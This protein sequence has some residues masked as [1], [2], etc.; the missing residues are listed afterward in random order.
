MGLDEEKYRLKYTV[1]K[2]LAVKITRRADLAD[3]AQEAVDRMV[4]ILELESGWVSFF[5][6]KQNVTHEALSG[7]VDKNQ[8]I[9]EIDKKAIKNL[10]E[11]FGAGF[12]FF[13][14]EKEGSQ[15][16]FS[17]SIKCEKKVLGAIT[18][19]SKGETDFSSEKEFL[20][21]LSSQLALASLRI[22]KIPEKDEEQKKI[23]ESERL[24][25]IMQVAVT[26]NHEINNPLTAILGNIQLV[27]EGKERLDQRTEQKLKAIE[28]GALKI[29]EITK[30]LLSIIEPVITEYA[31]GVK[32]LDLSK[33]L[34]KNE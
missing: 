20:E 24:S 29:A 31:P 15:T 33:S 7:S 22:K 19:L 21:A 10:R 8:L 9:K 16:L 23:I 1:L 4:E 12:V 26:I 18:G 5:D 2:N 32:M 14:L 25:A 11:E 17:Y 13:S 28:K 3:I 34:K 30:S 6:Q 27:L